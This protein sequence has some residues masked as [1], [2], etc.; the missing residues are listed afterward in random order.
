MKTPKKVSK[1][2]KQIWI[3]GE[4][5][6][7]NDELEDLGHELEVEEVGK[8]VGPVAVH[9]R[10]NHVQHVAQKDGDERDKENEEFKA[11]KDKHGRPHFHDLHAAHHDE[12]EIDGR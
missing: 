12:R 7:I 5:Y 1:N 2:T 10:V 3:H 11:E 9:A 6:Q 8:L 4:T